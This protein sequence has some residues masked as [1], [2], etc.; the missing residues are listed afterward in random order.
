MNDRG[1]GKEA[2]FGPRFNMAR[3]HSRAS[4]PP[5]PCAALHHFSR[6]INIGDNNLFFNGVAT[7]REER[8]A[9]CRFLCL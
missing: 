2:L 3:C 9:Y 5:V 8:R 6:L 1:C 7:M 4:D